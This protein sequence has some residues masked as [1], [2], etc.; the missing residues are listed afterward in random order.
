LAEGLLLEEVAGQ[1]I[2]DLH[3]RLLPMK[4]IRMMQMMPVDITISLQVQDPTPPTVEDHG[5]MVVDMIPMVHQDMIIHHL[6]HQD[7][8]VVKQKNG[9]QADI[10]QIEVVKVGVSGRIVNI[11]NT[12]LRD[13]VIIKAQLH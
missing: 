1:V 11:M 2:Q 8:I 7:T 6:H 13:G 5:E 10:L 12:I 4:D 9:G 3:L